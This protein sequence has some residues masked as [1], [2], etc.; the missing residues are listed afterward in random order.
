M[1][2]I[3]RNNLTYKQYLLVLLAWEIHTYGLSV[4]TAFG[5]YCALQQRILG[6]L[7]HLRTDPSRV[8]A[9]ALAIMEGLA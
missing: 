7:P 8:S 4:C 1:S 9:I 5:E 6:R 2:D 3:I